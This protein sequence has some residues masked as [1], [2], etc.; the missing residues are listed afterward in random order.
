MAYDYGTGGPLGASAASLLRPRYIGGSYQP[1][2]Y[3][4]PAPISSTYTPPTFTPVPLRAP[5]PASPYTP[6]SPPGG[7]PPAMP[8]AGDTSVDYSQDPILLKA[9]ALAKQ[10]I[11]DAESY[12]R[13]AEA[14]NL[15]LYGDP[16][17]VK[18]T[19]GKNAKDTKQAAKN[20]PFST[21]AELA[22]WNQRSQVGLD[23]NFNNQNLFYSTARLRGKALQSEDYQRQQSKTASQLQDVL[24][25]IAQNLLATRQQSQAMLLS[26]EEAAYQRALAEAAA[27]RYY[28]TTTP[29]ATGGA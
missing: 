12:A 18:Q 25:Q 5:N 8:G 26:E 17:L 4:A 24:A 23:E 1:P 22:R 28:A 9:Q 7:A 19:L 2:A 10:Q 6:Y 13:E 21:V 14:Q 16:Q 3:T 11:A 27:Q 20:N 15:I 29:T